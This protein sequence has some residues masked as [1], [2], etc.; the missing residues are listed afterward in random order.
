MKQLVTNAPVLRYYSLQDEVTI[1]C[2]ASQS[3]LG[4]TLLQNRQSVEYSSRALTS[5]ETHYAQTE[6]ELLAIV[7]A[8]Q[9][10]DA[11]IYGRES[12]QVET[13]N[14]SQTLGADHTKPLRHLV[15]CRGCC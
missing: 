11:Y 3:G 4:A 2:D 15:G 8:C 14:K 13:N 7:F 12:V 10:Y 5:A 1:Q 9:Q 6:K